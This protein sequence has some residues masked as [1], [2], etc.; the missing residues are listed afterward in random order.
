VLLAATAA[1]GQRR[2]LLLMLAGGF[3]L[4]ILLSSYRALWL[5]TSVALALIVARRSVRLRGSVAA[6]LATAAVVSI[7]AIALS[8]GV[9]ARTELVGSALDRTGGYR[10]SEARIGMQA[11]LEEPLAGRGLGQ[12]EAQ[13]FLPGF[14]VTD[15][16]PVY[17]VFYVMLLANGGLIG[18]ALLVW[19]LAVAARRRGDHT[20]AYRS[21]LAGF[22]VAAAFAGPTDGHWELGLVPALILLSDRFARTTADAPLAGW[23]P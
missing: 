9:R 8:G 18:L 17:H 16:G 21:L 1:R 23:H 11:F 4:D 10:A 13:I 22:A 2:L 6:S 5:A 7:A 15:V 20:L 14:R 19:P 3:V 12:V